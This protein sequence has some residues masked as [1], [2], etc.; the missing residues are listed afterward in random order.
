MAPSACSMPCDPRM[1][2]LTALGRPEHAAALTLGQWGM[3]VPLARQTGLLGRLCLALAD[4]G[5]LDDIPE[6]PRAHLCSARLV[7]AK[8]R[9]DVL[10][11]IRLIAEA[12]APVGA[13]LLLKGAAYVAAGLPPA[14]GRL[15][16]DIDVMVPAASLGKAEA[17]LMLAGWVAD[18]A[19][20]YDAA[21]YRRWMHQLPPMRHLR[22][23]T[24]VDLH[25]AI[26]PPTARHPVA[27]TPI[28]A[29]ARPALDGMV[30]VPAPEDLI[31]HS[32]VHLLDE[33]EFTHGLRD[34][35][36]IDLLLRHSSALTGFHERLAERAAE[37]GL[38]PVLTQALRQAS[39]LLGTPVAVE[40]P[41]TFL[42]AVYDLALQPPHDSC[43]RWPTRA[44]HALLYLRAHLLRM[45][46]RLLAP[47]LARKAWRRVGHAFS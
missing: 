12:L 1:L 13:P 30:K 22:R 10:G 32:A 15:F 3:V 5:L 17:A 35:S 24:V 33:G 36:D 29:A 25:H 8:H 46:L 23:G 38:A 9:R 37:L 16:A 20:P 4:A 28:L 43:R 31:L 11:E 26:R 47:H 34:L 14:D 19:E 39:R 27:A 42:T 7:A 2:L 44:A 21:Y 40:R 18:G 45:P 6:A 41:A